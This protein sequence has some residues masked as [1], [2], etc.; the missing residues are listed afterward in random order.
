MAAKV[1]NNADLVRAIYGFG[2]EHRERWS[3]VVLVKSLDDVVNDFCDSPYHGRK[4]VDFILFLKDCYTLKERRSML[5]RLRLC[6]CCS[7]HSHYKDERWKPVNPVPESK[8]VETC[9]CTCRHTYRM[10]RH[11]KVDTL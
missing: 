4:A 9:H 8:K 3:K 2:G 6:H 5:G 7:R 10:L 1:F 11:A